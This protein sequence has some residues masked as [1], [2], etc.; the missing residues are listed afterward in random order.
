MK[1]ADVAKE[2]ECFEYAFKVYSEHIRPNLSNF[3]WS[4]IHG[5]L[6]DDNFVCSTNEE[7]VC[8]LLGLIDFSDAISSYTVFDGA[9]FIAYMMM[10]Y[11]TNPLE[12]A[13]PAIAGCLNTRHL[14]EQEFDCLYHLV[15]C[16]LTQSTLHA[17]HSSVVFPDNKY[18]TRTLKESCTALR[19]LLETPKQTVD[20]RWRAA[21]QKATLEFAS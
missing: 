1:Y 20:K 6:N 16:Q 4:V 9:N 17:L 10:L 19:I 14:N 12:Y 7:G 18:R 5:D 11:C 15:V 3:Q 8:N 21:Q 13:E 2:R